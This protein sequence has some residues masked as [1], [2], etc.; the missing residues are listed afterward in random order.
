[1][2]NFNTFMQ[3]RF[4][5]GIRVHYGEWFPIKSVCLDGFDPTKGG[6]YA[7]VDVGGGKGHE[8]ELI[9]TKHPGMKGR[10]ILEDLPAV[11]GDIASLDP[12]IERLSHDFT[13]PQPIVG[14][15]QRRSR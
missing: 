11:I 8:S 7:F 10:I 4:N 2:E 9:L 6:E 3:G 5:T 15:Y 13:Q 12:R 1:M 14:K